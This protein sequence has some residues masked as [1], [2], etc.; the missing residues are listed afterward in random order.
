MAAPGKQ[1]RVWPW[2]GLVL[3]SAFLAAGC[4]GE[5]WGTVG[6]WEPGELGGLSS[7]GQPP[8]APPAAGPHIKG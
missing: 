5:F 2:L 1:K 7:P 6:D 4:G 3:L 8:A